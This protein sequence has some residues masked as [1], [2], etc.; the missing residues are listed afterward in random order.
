L[1]LHEE[2]KSDPRHRGVSQKEDEKPVERGRRRDSINF[3]AAVRL[4]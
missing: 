2:A 1:I 3:D 4:P